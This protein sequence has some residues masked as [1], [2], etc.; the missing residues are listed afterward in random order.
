M[1]LEELNFATQV[2]A[3]KRKGA[4][5]S[6]SSTKK[7]IMKR[8]KKLETADVGQLQNIDRSLATTDRDVRTAVR[9]LKVQLA[10]AKWL[11]GLDGGRG[12]CL[13]Y[14]GV[15]NREFDGDLRQIAAVKL[16]A[17]ININSVFGH[18]EPTFFETIG[19]TKLGHKLLFAR[20]IV[21]LTSRGS[22]S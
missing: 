20:G 12:S 5:V 13:Q 15:L 1:T 19:L 17:P 18:I 11:K 7:L 22:A 14:L 9:R 2:S 8:M 16:D 21:A 10:L 4:Q 3:T 6:M